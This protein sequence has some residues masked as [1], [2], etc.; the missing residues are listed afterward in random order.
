[1][2][3]INSQIDIIQSKINYMI[4]ELESGYIIMISRPGLVRDLKEIQMLI[5][6]MKQ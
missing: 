4:S 3:T 5:E 2:S 6:E 1:M